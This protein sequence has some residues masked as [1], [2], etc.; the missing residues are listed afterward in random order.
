MVPLTAAVAEPSCD[1]TATVYHPDW[2]HW[3]LHRQ[4]LKLAKV[5]QLD[6]AQVNA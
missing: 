6:G 3:P 2:Q 1:Q 4:R 5:G